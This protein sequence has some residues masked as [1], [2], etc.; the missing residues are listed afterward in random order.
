MSVNSRIKA[1]KIIGQRKAKERS[2]ERLKESKGKL[3]IL[4]IALKIEV[5]SHGILH[6]LCSAD[7]SKSFSGLTVSIIIFSRCIFQ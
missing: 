3:L 5:T 7:L 6:Y 2:K 1:T 4:K